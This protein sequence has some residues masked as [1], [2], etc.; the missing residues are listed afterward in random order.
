MK[1]ICLLFFA[2]F[3]QASWARGEVHDLSEVELL[4]TYCKGTDQIRMITNDPKSIA[5]Y[6]AI[7]GEAYKHLHHYCW[8]LNSENKLSRMRNDY[9]KQS[10]MTY[11]LHNVQYV[12]DRAPLSFS[13]IP[14]MYITKARILFKME[15]DVEAIGALFKLTQ[16]RPGYGPGYAQLGDYYQ[17]IGDRS[18]AIKFYQLGLINTNKANAQFFTRKIRKI[19]QHYQAPAIERAADKPLQNTGQLIDE[20]T[21]KVPP[22]SPE[23]TPAPAT[24]VAPRATTGQDQ[25]EKP[26]PYCRFC[27]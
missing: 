1:T 23:Q 6:A 12:L 2:L 8:A 3:S 18:N 5:E 15:Q 14:D 4:P 26:N 16:I 20:S 21:G 27:P 25:A 9:E 11:I 22:D 24:P 7:Y 19:D 13:L 10:E 17:R